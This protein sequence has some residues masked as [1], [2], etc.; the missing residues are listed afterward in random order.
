MILIDKG[1][2]IFYYT[3]MQRYEK[4]PSTITFRSGRGKH[5]FR[6]A[7]LLTG[8]EVRQDG[9]PVDPEKVLEEIREIQ[10]LGAPFGS[11]R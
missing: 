4:G 9:P 5:T 3:I 2:A 10:S 8:Q 7:P 6:Q 11:K 1:S